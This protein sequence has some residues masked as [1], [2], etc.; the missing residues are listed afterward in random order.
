MVISITDVYLYY[1]LYSGLHLYKEQ[2]VWK[3]EN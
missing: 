3:K 1:T 2:A